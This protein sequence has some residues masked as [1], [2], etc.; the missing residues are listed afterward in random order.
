MKARWKVLWPRALSL[1]LA[2]MFALA[3]VVL[4]GALGLY[5][6]QSL[7]RE[8]AWRDDAAL[9]GRVERMRALIGDGDSIDALRRRPQL[10]ANM[11]GSQG[12]LLWVLDGA[13]QPL[14]EINPARLAI[15]AL[16]PGPGVQLQ[17]GAGAGEPS[18][19]AWL[20]VRQDG[21]ALTL[22]A[23]KLL[24]ERSQMLAAYRLKLWLALGAGAL[25]AFLLGWAVSQRGL[26]PVRTLA[27]RAAAIDVQHLHLRL[28]SAQQV[29]ELR[30]LGDALNQMLA[31][32]E[33][34]FG[35]LSRFSEDLAHEM[36]TPLNNLMG[37]TQL[38][39]QKTRTTED[40]QALL[41]SSQEEYERL[42]RMI[43][44][45]LFLARAERPD[46][47]LHREPIALHEAVA[48][49]CD[50]FEG[51]AEERDMVLVNEAE[52]TLAADPQL[53]RRALA[54]LLANALRYG[55]ADSPVRIASQR[56]SGRVDISVSN[57]GEPIASEHL[58]RLF[59][60][61]YRCDPSRAQPGDSG[62]LGLAIVRSIMQLH[63]GAVRV[64]SSSA[65]TCS[66]LNFPVQLKSA[67]H[68]AAEAAAVAGHGGVFGRNLAVG[69]LGFG[70]FHDLQDGDVGLARQPVG[71]SLVAHQNFQQLVKRVGPALA[72]HQPAG[73]VE[74]GVKIALV[75]RDFC[76]KYA[77]SARVVAVDSYEIH[78]VHP[79][80]ERVKALAHRGLGNHRR[81]R[82]LGIVLAAQQ[83]QVLDVVKARLVIGR[84]GGNGFLQLFQ[85]GF[86][87]GVGVVGGQFGFRLGLK[88]RRQVLVQEFL[89]FSFGQRA[90]EAVHR[91]AV[92]QEDAGRDA[93]DAKGFAQLLLLVG[94]NLD[95]LEA[96][97]VGHFKFFKNRA[98]RLARAA[99][100]RPEV[101]QHGNS[102]GSGNDFLFKIGKGD[103]D[104]DGAEVRLDKRFSSVGRWPVASGRTIACRGRRQPLK[105]PAPGA[106]PANFTTET[107]T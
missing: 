36:R 89:D 57:Q 55:S 64:N 83:Q 30:Q 33:D 80:L 27:A 95:Q 107:P 78:S 63:G 72:G 10:Y 29:S 20:Q 58:P 13:G 81:K 39:L 34:G 71:P 52:G 69:D 2:L 15:P 16:P 68:H 82:H 62:G 101:N 47:V 88:R 99:P 43:D 86:G 40:Y 44:N 23:G 42:A 32:L 74:A 59:D 35:R 8:I 1:R 67:Q 49:L 54:N 37:Q 24:A 106:P 21:R 25:L 87:A 105:S 103:V 48:Q 79:A 50:Y 102:H 61:F 4:L 53:L 77:S 3:S 46:A 92:H 26:R 97:F 28:D 51:M 60:H 70:R 45:M 22:I 90:G 93:A 6:Y 75:G 96:A 91:L 73:L 11:L 85:H 66:T 65:G 18:R 104:H 9:L 5:L 19:L 41:A 12:D 76:I 100:G 14:I 94:I 98:E 17:D 7:A 31:R 56:H 84:V 38:A